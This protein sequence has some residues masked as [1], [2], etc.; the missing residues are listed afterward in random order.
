VT[1]PSPLEDGSEI[2]VGSERLVFR[3]SVTGSTRT[4]PVDS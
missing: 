1:T 3:V 4:K 2:M